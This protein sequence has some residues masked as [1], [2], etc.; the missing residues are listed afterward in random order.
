MRVAGHEDLQRDHVHRASQCWQLQCLCQRCE[1]YLRASRKVEGHAAAFSN[2]ATFS[3]RPY[4]LNFHALR[5][6]MATRLLRAGVTASHAK[7]ITRH[8]ST[9]VL[10]KHYNALDLTDAKAAMARLPSIEGVSNTANNSPM[11]G[12]PRAAHCA[13]RRSLLPTS[14]CANLHFERDRKSLPAP[15]CLE[16]QPGYNASVSDDRR[17]NTPICADQNALPLDKGKPRAISAAG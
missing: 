5:T 3:M 9:A 11:D 15:D 8:A 17:V 6:T 2:G 10:E 13:A 16:P 12:P 1:S 14:D 7:L 4:Q